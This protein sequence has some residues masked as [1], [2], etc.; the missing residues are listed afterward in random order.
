MADLETVREFAANLKDTLLAFIYLQG[1]ADMRPLT[2]QQ[3]R[4]IM[5]DGVFVPEYFDRRSGFGA[6]LLERF[7]DQERRLNLVYVSLVDQAGA[8]ARLGDVLDAY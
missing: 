5:T 4:L 6:K 7:R 1:I 8:R 2:A 3:G